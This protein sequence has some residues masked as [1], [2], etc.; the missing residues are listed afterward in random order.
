MSNR[1][2]IVDPDKCKPHKC[3][4]ECIK[5]CPPQ[6]TGSEVIVIQDIE[7]LSIQQ[8]VI[9]HMSKKQIA[10]IVES[11]CIGCNICVNRCPFNAIK[12]INL[13]YEKKEDIVHRYTP[14]GFRL[15]GFPIMKKNAVIG[16]IGENGIGK[17]TLIEILSDRLRPNFE[18]FD[19]VIEPKT[20]IQKYR[21][22]VLQDYLKDLYGGHL[23]ISI[24]QQKLKS[25]FEEKHFDKT[26]EE[27][28]HLLGLDPNV[29]IDTI[30]YN[31]LG[32]NNIIKTKI[33]NLSGGEMQKLLCLITAYGKSDVY[34][35][36]EPSNYLDVKQRLEVCRMIRSLV[37]KDKYVLVIEHDLSMLD[38][39]S[40]ELYIMYGVPAAYGVVSKPLTVLEGINMY[41]KGYIVSQN[42]RFRAD[43]YDFKNV[44]EV[45]SQSIENTRSIITHKYNEKRIQFHDF[46]LNI[47][48]QDI[49]LNSAIY[50]VLGENGTGKST[51]IKYLASSLG[52][53]VSYKEQ[54]ISIEGYKVN[55]LYPT[56]EELFYKYIAIQYTDI[57]FV[58]TVVR[59]L[60]I[61]HIKNTPINK[62]SGGEIQK[63]M[64]IMCLGTPADIYLIDE[65]SAHIDIDKRLKMT[66]ILRNYI[67]ENKKCA[68]VI[69]HDIMMV[70]ALGQ[71]INNRIIMTEKDI[72]GENRSYTI[73]E[74][75]DFDNGINKFL[76]SLDISMRTSTNNGRPRINKYMSQLD[77]E[78]KKHNHYYGS[79]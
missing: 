68:F 23:H 48:S 31:N 59:P 36:D 33:C 41:L 71:D 57:N 18:V 5:N 77:K 79:I 44:I 69:E 25:H 21:G 7:D 56:V 32:L 12:I 3:K 19:R 1:I 2:A 15:Y 55:S 75:M 9:Q 29:L 73:S 74:Y 51:F 20:I 10:K 4:K 40:D 66:K 45:T 70:V 39:I 17:T 47:R 60:D 46:K 64:I 65:P 72:S 50:L 24:K 67:I 61:E 42:I 16:L 37:D 34:I 78:Q 27:Y 63:V 35:F 43:E 52:I 38:F 26:V 49:V 76:K 8:N 22:S 6:Q 54:N 28:Y 14:N 53:T 58:K 62:L 13:P 30:H 11:M